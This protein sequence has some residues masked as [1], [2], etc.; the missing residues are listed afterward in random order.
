MYKK[1]M[2]LEEIE[3]LEQD[4]KDVEYNGTSGMYYNHLWFTIE[5]QDVYV[6]QD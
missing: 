1:F 4:G 6:K 2:T 5:G 3:Q